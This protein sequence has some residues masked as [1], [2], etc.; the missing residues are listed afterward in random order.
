MS[1]P[2]ARHEQRADAKWSL[3]GIGQTFQKELN[4]HKHWTRRVVHVDQKVTRGEHLEEV[5]ILDGPIDVEASLV[6]RPAASILIIAKVAANA[7]LRGKKDGFAGNHGVKGHIAIKPQWGEQG[8]RTYKEERAA[9]GR[10]QC[11]LDRFDESLPAAIIEEKSQI[12]ITNSSKHRIF[13]QE[14]LQLSSKHRRRFQR[15]PRVNPA[16]ETVGCFPGRTEL[17]QEHIHIRRV[18]K[19]QTD[20]APSLSGMPPLRQSLGHCAREYLISAP[21]LIYCHLLNTR[22]RLGIG[23][24]RAITGGSCKIHTSSSNRKQRLEY[25]AVDS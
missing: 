1:A 20:D 15:R 17:A 19:I 4:L 25:A 10:L 21:S 23:I 7:G 8:A 12:A 6:A 13:G 9:I 18:I 11:S 24:V 5:P 16:G 14:F 3:S 2:Y 22:R